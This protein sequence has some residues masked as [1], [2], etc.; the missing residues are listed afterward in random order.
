MFRAERRTRK[1]QRYLTVGVAASRFTPSRC[2]ALTEDDEQK[3][4]NP[5]VHESRRPEGD[6]DYNPAAH[7]ECPHANTSIL[8]HGYTHIGSQHIIL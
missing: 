4:E 3:E 8:A 2:R 5:A 6:P 7:Y 1:S